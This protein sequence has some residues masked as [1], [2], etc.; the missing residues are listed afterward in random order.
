M[1]RNT[2]YFTYLIVIVPNNFYAIAK[3]PFAIQIHLNF[4]QTLFKATINVMF[5]HNR[6]FS[7]LHTLKKTSISAPTLCILASNSFSN[8]KNKRLNAKMQN[9]GIIILSF[10]TQL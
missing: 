7:K 8:K 9:C 3:F 6:M 4:F 1:N 10:A 5:F 2:L